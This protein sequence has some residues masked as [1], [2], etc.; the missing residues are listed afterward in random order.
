M[1]TGTNETDG[2]ILVTLSRGSGAPAGDLVPRAVTTQAGRRL[3]GVGRVTCFLD[4]GGPR[5]ATVLRTLARQGRRVVVVPLTLTTDPEL[6]EYAAAGARLPGLGPDAV[7]VTPGIGPHP[8]LAEAASRQLV[9]AGAR[10]ADAVVLVGAGHGAATTESELQRAAEL[11]H[12]RRRHAVVRAAG[13]T[14]TG[15]PVAETV[16]ELR[17]QGLRVAVA[18]YLLGSGPHANRASALARAS[19][20]DVLADVLGPHRLVVELVA[21]RYLGAVGRATARSAARGTG[22][23]AARRPAA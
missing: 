1:S 9:A 7:R 22:R 6:G 13:V 17:A 18:P 4:G 23:A 3:G 10:S 12:A 14:G 11:L 19:G 21:R 5:Y 15:A 2:T 20:A 16:A 8:L